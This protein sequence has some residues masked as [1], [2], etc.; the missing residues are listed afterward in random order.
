MGEPAEQVRALPEG[1]V[2]VDP[3][4]DRTR[5]AVLEA[6]RVI[7]LE[8]GWEAVTHL[9]VAERSGVGRTTIYRHWR[10]RSELLRDALADESIAIHTAPTGDI[11]G[12]LVAELEAIRYVLVQ[13]DMG[14]VLA[15]LVDRAERDPDLHRLKVVLVQDGFSAI[16]RLLQNA[17]D[18]GEL[19]PELDIDHGIA[20]LVGPIVY[21]RLVSGE[22]L[23][24]TFSRAVVD[25]FLAAHHP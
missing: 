19:R 4:V 9:R 16:R 11:R 20:Q 6:A 3:R 14:R 18:G 23:S 13:R 21:R 17:M 7:L 1:R 8:E 5:A 2:K 25:D 15:A 22:P 24:A 12:D 10:E